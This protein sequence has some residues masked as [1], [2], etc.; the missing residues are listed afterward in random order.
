LYLRLWNRRESGI[1]D[2]E[3]FLARPVPAD[4]MVRVAVDVRGL[5]TRIDRDVAKLRQA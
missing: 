3:L 5:R 1:R 2:R 4:A